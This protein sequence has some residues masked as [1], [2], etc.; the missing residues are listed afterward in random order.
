MT[1]AIDEQMKDNKTAQRLPAKGNHHYLWPKISNGGK[2][3]SRYPRCR[4]KK[5]T[6]NCG[7]VP[8]QF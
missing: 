4:V 6:P 2:T 1:Q 5:Q 8:D 3:C 7:D